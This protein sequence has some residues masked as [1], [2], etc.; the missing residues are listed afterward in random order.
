M[1]ARSPLGRIELV[2]ATVWEW[3]HETTGTASRAHRWPA[4]SPP[5]APHLSHDQDGRL[6][7]LRETWPELAE[8]IESAVELVGP[9]HPA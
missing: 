9:D 4:L 6:E 3:D 5:S 1:A 8:R 7:Q 2:L